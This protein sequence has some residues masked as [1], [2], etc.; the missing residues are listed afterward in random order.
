M[1]SYFSHVQFFA[2]LWTVALQASLSMAFSRQEYWSELP[3]PAP[4]DLPDPGIQLRFLCILQ[5]DSL[6]TEPPGRP[7][8]ENEY[9]KYIH[10]AVLHRQQLA[11]GYQSNFKY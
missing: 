6:C 1:L 10:Q 9:L 5:I 4:R 7:N 3:C 8:K 11:T 2:I